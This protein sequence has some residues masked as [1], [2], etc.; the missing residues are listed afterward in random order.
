M[1]LTRLAAKQK[2]YIDIQHF[3]ANQAPTPEIKL[4]LQRALALYRAA[5]AK[6]WLEKDAPNA[7]TEAQLTN[8]ERQL[9]T[10]HNQARL[11]S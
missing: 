1:D 5:L 7:E 11:L 2:R 10:L 8:L 9:D 6:S 4:Q 3:T